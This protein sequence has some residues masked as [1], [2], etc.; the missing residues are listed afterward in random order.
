MT[1]DDTQ[2]RSF[3]LMVNTPTSERT[4]LDS[5]WATRFPWTGTEC[6][7]APGE[8][9]DTRVLEILASTGC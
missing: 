7:S 4:A 1:T 6:P 8:W 9:L 5:L 3:P 2:P